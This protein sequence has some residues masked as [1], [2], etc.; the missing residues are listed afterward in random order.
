MKLRSIR[1]QLIFWNVATLA[2]LLL[3][4][5][6]VVRLTVQSVLISSVDQQ[7]VRRTEPMPGPPPGMA[8]PDGQPGQGPPPTP[9][10]GRIFFPGPPPGQNRPP[11]EAPQVFPL[12][13]PRPQ[14]Q[15]APLDTSA[16]EKAE[17]GSMV[18]E[19]VTA[20]AQSVRVLYRPV[21][22][23]PHPRAVIQAQYPLDDIERA[24]AGLDQA[25]LL[26]TPVGM[27]VAALGGIL[28]TRRVLS[29]VKRLSSAAE[30]IGATD[31]SQRLPATGADEFA[32]LAGTLNGL[33]DRLEAAF[34]SQQ[35]LL[36][37]QRRFVADASHELKTPL[38]VV[39]GT[40]DQ[41]EHDSTLSQPSRE[42]AAEIGAAARRMSKMV[43]DLLLL[44]R[45]DSGHLAQQPIEL[46]LED[47]LASALA[48]LGP[49]AKRVQISLPKHIPTVNGNEEELVRLFGNLL[50]NAVRYSPQGPV[51][52]T[53]KTESECVEVAIQDS[54]PGVSPDQLKHLGERF[55]RVDAA[56]SS[57]QGGTGL[58]LSIAKAIAE[59]H[60]GEIDFESPPGGGLL[61]KVRLPK[62]D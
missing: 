42:A 40:A 16:L 32:D 14:D 49:N 26:L 47:L 44:A 61:V 45:S 53:A 13:M 6:V 58:G 39:Q 21:P 62:A 30:G 11:A 52:V 38:T 15:P 31:L 27:L 25:L 41:L 18:F 43:G 60:G 1:S 59:A 7:L 19:T 36:E 3:V 24:I 17:G 5:G 28:L 57:D 37:Q 46:T 33:L 10:F 12:G 54:G 4:L 56:R 51:T 8:P 9:N 20:Q 50:E 29:R 22:A 35:K 2:L 23:G 55:Y 34:T 48:R